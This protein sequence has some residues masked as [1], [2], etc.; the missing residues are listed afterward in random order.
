MFN[1]IKTLIQKD[2]E[3]SQST[4]T[5]LQLLRFAKVDLGLNPIKTMMDWS[6]LRLSSG[7]I[8]LNEYFLY[9]LY[10]N[11]LSKNEKKRFIRDA[12]QHWVRTFEIIGLPQRV[13]SNKAL[14]YG[15]LEEEGIPIPKTFGMIYQK[16][17]KKK[18][19]LIIKNPEDLRNLLKGHKGQKLFGKPNF[20]L[21]SIG[22][23][24]L[25]SHTNDHL[26][27]EGYPP[28]S[29]DRFFKKIIGSDAFLI[30]N[31]V[32][33]HKELKKFTPYTCTVRTYNIIRGEEIHSP[34]MLIKIPTANNI[35]DNFWR[36]GNI[37][38]AINIKTGVIERAVQKNG[39]LLAE[40]HEHP[41][42]GKILVGFKIPFWNDILETNRKT[43]MVCKDLRYQAL[44]IAITDEGPIVI[45]VNNNG[46]FLLP[47][48]SS[49]KGFLTDELLHFIKR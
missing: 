3:I 20:G 16:P 26:I 38:A 40:I 49:G 42:T 36:K 30:Q 44:D 45:E 41:D 15:I 39:P 11:K 1:R 43:A 25:K 5:A 22:V 14:I 31:F 29:Y 2:I 18:S 8:S 17:S 37:V 32:E 7:K 19:A 28:I 10:S 35:A 9:G 12:N 4:R 46:S 23:F 6:L 27:L 34:F 24:I 33:N 13:I 48:A 47:Q 21:Q